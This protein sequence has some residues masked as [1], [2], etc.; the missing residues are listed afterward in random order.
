MFDR[1]GTV[2]CV[3]C[4]SPMATTRVNTEEAVFTCKNE[5]C[6]HV[7]RFGLKRYSRGPEEDEQ[8]ASA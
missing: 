4:M 5:N 1:M 3:E 2:L 8:R 7:S 6:G